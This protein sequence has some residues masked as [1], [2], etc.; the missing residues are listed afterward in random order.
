MLVPR[1]LVALTLLLA[2]CNQLESDE[3]KEVARVTQETVE[4]GVDEAAKAAD[5]AAEKTKEQIDRID[6][7]KLRRAWD[8]AVEVMEESEPSGSAS[9][10]VDPLADVETA[11]RC[12]E[13]RERCT[14][15]HDFARRAREHGSE[16]VRQVGVSAAT[17]DVRGIRVD[18]IRAGS[19][20]ERV[21]F[22]SG[23]VVTHV[24]GVALGSP[25]DAMMLYMNV[26]S[27][28]RFEVFY[29]RGQEERSLVVDVV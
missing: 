1:V 18:S 14:V 2:G 25:Q 20:A 28:R 23:D 10:V 15:T 27:A 3:A 19:I 21:G 17:G 26:R 8:A 6:V 16:V 4:R 29:F 13:A 5:R 7:D 12:D 9:P 22:R 24:N 11:I